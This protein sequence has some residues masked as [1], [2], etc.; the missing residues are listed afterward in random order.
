MW[1]D[2]AR[3]ARIQL[4]KLAGRVRGRV[5][6]VSP[7]LRDFLPL[8][9]VVGVSGSA[10]LL[11]EMGEHPAL[12]AMLVVFI[13]SAGIWLSSRGTEDFPRMAEDYQRK[14]RG[15]GITFRII[16]APIV[17]LRKLSLWGMWMSGVFGAFATFGLP[18]K[19]D[20]YF[21]LAG[22]FWMIGL[23]VAMTPDFGKKEGRKKV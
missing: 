1:R 17:W 22:F 12:Q 18:S 14:N 20:P 10:L 21:G 4:D 16:S 13:L 5:S 6:K 15:L 3:A 7:F 23:G 19:A 2:T 9:P 11:R 8:G